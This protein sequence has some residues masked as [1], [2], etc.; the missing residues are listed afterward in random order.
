MNDI[1]RK[2]IFPIIFLD[3]MTWED[4]VCE[5]V[6]VSSLPPKTRRG[7]GLNEARRDALKKAATLPI[8]KT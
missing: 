8:N 1:G 7:P 6:M 4:V 3:L 2:K 5:S